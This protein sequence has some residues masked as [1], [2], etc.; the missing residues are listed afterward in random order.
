MQETEIRRIQTSRRLGSGGSR[1]AQAKNR[2]VRPHLNRK[3]LGMVLHAHHPS[4]GRKCIT[5]GSQSRLAWAKTET[6]Y[7]K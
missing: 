6:L 1:P 7:P 2:F 4:D 3:K 5:E